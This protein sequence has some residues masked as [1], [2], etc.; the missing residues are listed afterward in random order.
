MWN[1]FQNQ[2]LG[3]KWLSALIGSGLSAVG[4]D[5]EGD[6]APRCSFFSMTQ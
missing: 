6:S 1:F 4:I 2:I 3:M 5:T